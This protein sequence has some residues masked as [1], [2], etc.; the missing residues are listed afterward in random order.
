MPDLPNISFNKFTAGL[1]SESDIN[2]LVAPDSACKDISNF[3]INAPS[4]ALKE[5]TGSDL[6]YAIPPLYGNRIVAHKN[7]K[8]TEPSSQEITTLITASPNLLKYS[9]NFNIGSSWSTT[10]ATIGITP[11]GGDNLVG[12]YTNFDDSFALTFNGFSGNTTRGGQSF[13]GNG[14][15]LRSCK[16]LLKRFGKGW[17]SSHGGE[18]VVPDPYPQYCW[19]ELYLDKGSTFGTNSAPG[20]DDD[21]ITTSVPRIVYVPGDAVNAYSLDDVD[22]RYEKFNF[23]GDITLELGVAYIIVFCFFNGLPGS[24]N[25]YWGGRTPTTGVPGNECRSITAGTWAAGTQTDMCYYVYSLD[26]SPV[27]PAITTNSNFTTITNIGATTKFEQLFSGIT[28]N[29]YTYSVYFRKSTSNRIRISIV[30]NIGSNVSTSTDNTNNWIRLSVTYTCTGNT[31]FL[32]RIDFPDSTGSDTCNIYGAQLET[33]SVASGYGYTMHY[34]LPYYILQRPYWNGTSW[35]DNWVELTE[36]ISGVVT[37]C[38]NGLFVILGLD[39]DNGYYNN[40]YAWDTTT[41]SPLGYVTSYTSGG[42][43]SIVGKNIT[44]IGHTVIVSRFPF[45]AETPYYQQGLISEKNITFLEVGNDLKISFGNTHRPLTVK[46]INTT[47]FGAAGSQQV[48]VPTSDITVGSFHTVMFPGSPLYSV[49]FNQDWFEETNAGTDYCEVKFGSTVGTPTVASY[50]YGL[51]DFSLYSGT[52]T[53]KVDIYCGTTLVH[54]GITRTLPSRAV[55]YEYTEYLTSTE[56]TAITGLSGWSDLRYRF[57]A[58]TPSRDYTARFYGSWMYLSGFTALSGNI[59]RNN[60]ILTYSCFMGTQP[61]TLNI[62]ALPSATLLESRGVG[63]DTSVITLTPSTGGTLVAGVYKIYVIGVM[64]GNQRFP[65]WTSNTTVSATG[66]IIVKIPIVVAGF[67][68]RLISLEIYIG[69]GTATA[70]DTSVYYLCS[71]ISIK[72]TIGS[73]LT[74]PVT[75]NTWTITVTVTALDSTRSTLLF[76]LGG[77][78]DII[79]TRARY[80]VAFYLLG[81]VFIAQT[82]E[83]G[84]VIRYSNIRGLVGETDKFAYSALGYGFFTSDSSANQAVINIGRTIEN[85]LLIIRENDVSLFEVQSGSSSAKRLRQLFTGIGS[86]NN[87]SLVISDYGNFW[88]DNNDVYWYQGGYTVPMKISKDKIRHYWRTTLAPYIATS[89]AIFNR[90]VN[91]YWI[92]IYN[93]TAWIVLRYSPEFG[94]WNIWTPNYT[95]VWLSEQMNGTV[96]IAQATNIYQY[97]GTL[98]TSA[99]YIITH[100]RKVSEDGINPKQVTEAYISDYSSNNNIT[101]AITID[102][103]ASPR[104]GNSPVFI[105]TKKSQRRAIRQGS[106]FNYATIKLSNNASGG[107]QIKEFGLIASTRKDRTSGRK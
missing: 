29:Q 96:T 31:G 55:Y 77:C 71:T 13:I 86:S 105:S 60:F 41:A 76:N 38:A 39:E 22:W 24:L 50:K 64:D 7:W 46:Y 54:A 80:N 8:V 19:A 97:G 69:T 106:S 91:E 70:G 73:V 84:N 51:M 92:F 6:V 52:V 88:Y 23:S 100:K 57:T 81:R 104:A 30:D 35:I 26:S 61:P 33:G 4:Y 49:S 65:I 27:S 17:F 53:F 28:G 63:Y 18:G 48:L 87:R 90:Q 68:W 72:D 3:E 93:G 20:T 58:Y 82:K 67:D 36:M 79:E 83:T 95:P 37:D 32:V 78:L 47:A 101:M 1:I 85:D 14:Q 25:V 59:I 44:T 99:P 89:F 45:F 9:E 102:N 94:N 62:P 56:I 66:S 12:S 74:T 40:W 98:I 34:N 15:K 5:S 2:A 103:E 42:R 75:D 11:F 43:F 21:P 107:T 16:F 10:S